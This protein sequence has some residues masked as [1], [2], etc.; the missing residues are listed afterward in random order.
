MNNNKKKQWNDNGEYQTGNGKVLRKRASRRSKRTAAH[1]KNR[2]K[3][4]EHAIREIGENQG[5][6]YLI[7]EREIMKAQSKYNYK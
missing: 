7:T 6:I 5:N 2:D 1:E 4:K 3:E